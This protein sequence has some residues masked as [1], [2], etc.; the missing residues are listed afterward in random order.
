M[1]YPIRTMVAGIAELTEED[2]VLVSAIRLAE[3]TGA[4]LHLVHAFELPDLMWD[5]YARMGYMDGEALKQYSDSLKARLESCA[6][7]I[8]STATVTCHAMAGPS[9]LMIDE[10]SRRESADLVLVSYTH[11]TLPT[12]VNV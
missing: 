6:G 3:R 12:N 9:A 2:P 10:I 4:A 7:A 1:I 8:S 11:L 5:A